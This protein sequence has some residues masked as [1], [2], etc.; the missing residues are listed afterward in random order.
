MGKDTGISW[1]DHTFNPFW[2]CIQVSPACGLPLPGQEDEPHGSCY[3][4]EWDARFPILGQTHWGKEAPRRFFGDKHWDQLFTWNRAAGRAS[5]QRN[6]FVGSMCDIMED[7]RSLKHAESSQG[8]VAARARL[9]KIIP[10]TP[11]LNYLMLTKRPQNYRTFLPPDW[12]EHPQ[13]NVWLGATVET[14]DYIWRADE[15]RKL[16]CA[17]RWLSMEPLLAM[18]TVAELMIVLHH[19]DWAI[20]GGES[21]ANAR[22]TMMAWIQSGMA[23]AKKTGTVP[24]M[25]Q[26]GGNLS[27]ADLLYFAKNSGVSMQHKAGA[28]PAEWPPEFRVQQFPTPRRFP[29]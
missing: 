29:A 8:I 10:E 11:H 3:A 27:D 22:R 5:V 4:L 26:T 20:F 9:Y 14:P 18:F 15:L 23:V 24:F 13:P 7:H 28:D 25:K 19:I 17:V 21:G 12:L 6:V 2:G 1:T 16:N